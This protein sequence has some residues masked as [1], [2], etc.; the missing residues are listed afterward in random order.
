MVV[1]ETVNE[2]NKITPE[3]RVDALLSLLEAT[4]FEGSMSAKD[5]TLVANLIVDAEHCN[6][7]VSIKMVG[8]ALHLE[9]ML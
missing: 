7:V 5:E 8:D 3:S 1:L 9:G 4:G 6:V 2:A